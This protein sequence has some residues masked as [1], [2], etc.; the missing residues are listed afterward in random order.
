MDQLDAELKSKED[1]FAGLCSCLHISRRFILESAADQLF[2]QKLLKQVTCRPAPATH[3]LLSCSKV[4]RVI[5][6]C[7]YKRPRVRVWEESGWK[8]DL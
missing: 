7:Q 2:R 3:Y 1:V 4:H 5:P 8:T 6:S